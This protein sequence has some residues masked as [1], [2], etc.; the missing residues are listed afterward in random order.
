MTSMS[1]GEFKTNFSKVI[2]L[3][4]S[5]EEVEILYGRAKEPVA[6][7]VPS[8]KKTGETLLG[9]LEGKA[10]FTMS[11]DFKMTSEELFEL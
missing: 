8:P 9:A 7:L 11:S 1:V 3:V 5:G 6:R 4:K 10:T 2:E